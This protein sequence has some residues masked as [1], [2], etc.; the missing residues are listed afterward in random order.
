MCFIKFPKRSLRNY[1]VQEVILNIFKVIGNAMKKLFW[2]LACSVLS[3]L[4]QKTLMPAIKNSK[5]L[6]PGIGRSI[7]RRNVQ[8]EVTLIHFIHSKTQDYR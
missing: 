3:V 6:K 8:S 2:V 7:S 1:D 5:C 4:P